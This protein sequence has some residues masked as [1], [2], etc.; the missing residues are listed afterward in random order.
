MPNAERLMTVFEAL[1]KR[2]AVRAY[3]PHV[4]AEETVRELLKEAVRAPTAMHAEPWSFVIIQDQ[5]LLKRYSDLAKT[6]WSAER[7]GAHTVAHPATSESHAKALLFQPDFNVFYD[8]ST[9]ILICARPLG[10]FVVADCWLAAE[11]LMLAACAM[12]LGTCCI[13]FGVPVFNRADVKEELG[14]PPEIVAVAPIIVGVPK[15][16]APQTPRKEPQVICW[17]R[18]KGQA[19]PDEARAD[20]LRLERAGGGR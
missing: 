17:R 8:A 20:S 5:S 1:A 16:A 19:A 15:E 3:R 6:T 12:G 11:N 14:I 7:D 9:L 2:H 10:S 18:G 13:G 4:V